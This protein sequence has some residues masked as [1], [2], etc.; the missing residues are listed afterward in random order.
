MKKISFIKKITLKKANEIYNDLKFHKND[1]SYGY[2]YVGVYIHNN[3]V[4][5]G[6][7]NRYGES[8]FIYNDE[9]RLLLIDNELA[10]NLLNDYYK[11]D[12]VRVIYDII[13]DYINY[14]NERCFLIW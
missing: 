10:T 7:S 12:A 4:K 6:Y 5:I 9:K 11:K 14:Y 8:D 1:N 13:N 3:T 2:G